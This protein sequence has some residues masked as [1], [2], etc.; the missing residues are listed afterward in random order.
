MGFFPGFMTLSGGAGKDVV[1][2]TCTPSIYVPVAAIPELG[3][4]VDKSLY[5]CRLKLDLMLLVVKEAAI[6]AALYK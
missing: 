2:R 1:K 6:P 5:P 3:I 4:I